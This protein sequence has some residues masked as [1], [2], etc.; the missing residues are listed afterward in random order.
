[1]RKMYFA[2][3]PKRSFLESAAIAVGVGA[4]LVYGAQRLLGKDRFDSAVHSLKNQIFN[5]G[6]QEF[7]SADGD[8]NVFAAEDEASVRDEQALLERIR[9][10]AAKG[11]DKIESKL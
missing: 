2:M 6:A 10:A 11:L 5:S 7:D 8:E 9:R 4:G 1:M 3:I